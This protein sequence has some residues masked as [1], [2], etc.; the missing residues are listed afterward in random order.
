MRKVAVL[1]ITV[2]IAAGGAGAW[3][4]TSAPAPFRGYTGAEQFVE[5]PPGAGTRTIGDRLVAAGVV[6]DAITFRIALALSGQAKRLKAGEYRFDEAMTPREVLG[7]IARGDVYVV[8]V[9]F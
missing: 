7:K 3:L 9:T 6:R 2:L 8:N 1:L 4:Y 5:I